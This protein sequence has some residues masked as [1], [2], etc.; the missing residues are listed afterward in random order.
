MMGMSDKERRACTRTLFFTGVTLRAKEVTVEVEA[1][2]LDISISGMYVRS[3]QVLPVGTLCTI[4]IKVTG[5]HS[6]LVLE[7]I[8]GEVVRKDRQGMAIQ[9]T[10]PM[11]W[12]VLFKIYTHYGR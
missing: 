6:C 10:S 8:L 4:E 1:D 7:D 9:F 2:L 5:N 11:E 12:F 3:E